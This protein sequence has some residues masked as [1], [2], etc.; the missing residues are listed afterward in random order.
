MRRSLGVLID[1]DLAVV[2]LGR[3]ST[4]GSESDV[5]V[6]GLVIGVLLR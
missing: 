1:V 2:A 6:P 3:A 4:D 5:S